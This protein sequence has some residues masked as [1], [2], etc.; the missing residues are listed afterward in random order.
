MRDAVLAHFEGVAV[1]ESDVTKE[2]VAQ[3]AIS[4]MSD[5]ADPWNSSDN[6]NERLLKMAR[7][8][9]SNREQPRINI[10][11]IDA[12]TSTDFSKRKFR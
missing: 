9:T 8:A 6:P 5:G 3:Q 4:A 1:P 12:T 11:T 10:P 7:A 2:Y